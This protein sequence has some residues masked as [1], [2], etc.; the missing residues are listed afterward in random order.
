[1]KYLLMFFSNVDK[2]ESGIKLKIKNY[3]IRIF[4]QEMDKKNIGELIARISNLADLIIEQ[5]EKL[6][7]IFCI[8]F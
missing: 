7:L 1:M 6:E 2:V 3:K 5:T 8:K 4:S